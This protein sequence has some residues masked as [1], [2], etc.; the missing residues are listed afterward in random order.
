MYREA[1]LLPNWCLYHIQEAV[2]TNPLCEHKMHSDDLEGLWED[3]QSSVF[4]TFII[5]HFS[6]HLWFAANFY[7]QQ[8]HAKQKPNFFHFEL[9][10]KF[11]SLTYFAL[12]SAKH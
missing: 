7:S 11:F 12:I 6:P 4:I 2:S 5:V 3:M 9:K 10:K 1:C 8:I